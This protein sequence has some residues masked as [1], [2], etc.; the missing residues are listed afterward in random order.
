MNTAVLTEVSTGS[1]KSS[2]VLSLESTADGNLAGSQAFNQALENVEDK[3][4]CVTKP[5]EWAPDEWYYEAELQ[6]YNA[7]KVEEEQLAREQRLLQRAI[8]RME[9][10]QE[11]PRFNL[12]E[13]HSYED[14]S[15]YTDEENFEALDYEDAY[16]AFDREKSP[17]F[18]F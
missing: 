13:D 2:A 10:K 1:V 4:E 14:E 7:W 11:L 17:K 3:V 5:E 15:Y 9:Q 16:L 12:F 6:D 18:H 8:N